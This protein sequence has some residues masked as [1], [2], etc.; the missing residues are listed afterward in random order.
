MCHGTLVEIKGPLAEWILSSH[1]V[2][3]EIKFSYEV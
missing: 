1:H 2:D 3:P